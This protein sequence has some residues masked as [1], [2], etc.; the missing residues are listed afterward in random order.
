[1]IPIKTKNE[2]E[3][4]RQGGKI[5]ATVLSEVVKAVKPGMTT[6]SLDVLAERLIYEN[7]A[8]PGFKSHEGYPATLCTS[9]NEEIVHALPS[10][11]KLKEGDIIGLDLGVLFPPEKCGSCPMA[12]GCGGQQ[13]MY[14]DAAVTVAVGKI[15]SQAQKL[16]EAARGALNEAITKIKPGRKLSDSSGAI[17]KYVE[18]SGFSVIRELVGHGIGCELHE[19]PEIPNFAGSNF[20]DVVLKEGLVLAIEPMVSAGSW[21]VKRSK[22]KFGYETEDKSLAAHFEHT[23]VVTEEGCRILT[24]L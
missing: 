7:G 3:I 14:T 13:G 24:I 5:L 9:V 22:D 19:A 6:Q 1:M 11:R 20:K 15:S 2:I 17:Q 10:E 8:L 23:V 21:R 18:N 16:I 12:Q 4:M